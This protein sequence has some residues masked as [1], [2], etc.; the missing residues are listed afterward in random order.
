MP[1]F[2]VYK[3]DG[4]VET[5]KFTKK[6]VRSSLKNAVG[7]FIEVL[8]EIEIEGERVAVVGCEE[9][10]PCGMHRNRHEHFKDYYGNIVV[11]LAKHM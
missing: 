4:S 10:I 2:D 11:I 8:D 6:D 1:S 5:V 3:A 7:G 9:A